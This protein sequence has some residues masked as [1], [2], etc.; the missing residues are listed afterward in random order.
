ML[1]LLSV[2]IY[3]TYQM[4]NSIR[5]LFISRDP[6]YPPTSGTSL[7]I[8]QNVNIMGKLSEVAFFTACR[9]EPTQNSLPKITWWQH[10]NVERPRPWLEKLS[11]RLW[12]LRSSGY[13]DTDWVY[14]K[15]AAKELEEFVLRVKPDIVI[16]EEVWLYRY[17]PIIKRHQCRTILLEHNVEYPLCQTKYSADSSLKGKLKTR[18]KLPRV[19]TIEKDF[20]NQVDQ[21]WTCSDRDVTVVKELYGNPKD[22]C[23]IPNGV[24]I[25]DYEE[26][27][28]GNNFER[29]PYDVMFLGQLSY[30]PNTEAVNELIDIIYPRLREIQ[31]ECRLLLVG[32][33]PTQKMLD[34][35]A[36]DPGIVVTGKVPKVLPYLGSAGMMVVPLRKGGGTRLKILEAFASGCPVISTSKGA[37]GLKAQDGEHLLIRDEIDSIVEAVS[38]LWSNPS[39]GSQ[40]ALAAYQLVQEEYSWEAIGER[41][42]QAIERLL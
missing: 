42:K 14:A 20:I 35:A 19:K 16:F 7:R 33:R 4:N 9:W 41:V 6:P 5:T 22:I 13:P 26:A 40:M 8:W 2:A 3:S 1:F 32:A 12:W 10:Y 23:V 21:V 38:T 18:L 34:A 17:L 29:K 39:L 30:E 25:H 36:N 37:E 24:N 27:Y 31:P 15:V 28:S 11:H